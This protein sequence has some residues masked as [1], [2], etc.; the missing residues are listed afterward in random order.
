MG[1]GNDD[2]TESGEDRTTRHLRDLLKSES[3]IAASRQRNVKEQKAVLEELRKSEES[4]RKE[5]EQKLKVLQA[6]LAAGDERLNQRIRVQQQAIE[7]AEA[8]G[9]EADTIARKREELA[10]LMLLEARRREDKEEEIRLQKEL[11]ATFGTVEDAG[12]ELA[13]TL[14]GLDNRFLKVLHAMDESK[15]GID[16]LWK[17]FKKAAFE[18]GKWKMAMGAGFLK[19]SELATAGVMALS[20]QILKLAFAQDE[21]ISGFMKATGAA[22]GFAAEI[23]SINAD[24]H[25]SGIS[26]QDAG[27]AFGGLYNTFTDFTEI[28]PTM[29]GELSR[30]VA[31]LQELGQSAAISGKILDIAMRSL[32][33]HAKEAGNL[34][35]EVTSIAQATRQPFTKVAQDFATVAPKL[36]KYGNNMMAVFEGLEKQAKRTGIQMGKLISV[37]EQFDTFEGAGRAVGRLNAILGGP[38]LN[39]I[40]MLNATDEERI[41]IL[42]RLTEQSG[43]QFD[44]LNRYEQMNIAKAMGTDV[45]TARRMMGASTAEFEKQQ[46]AQERLA[47]MARESQTLIDQLK[48]AFQSALVGMRPIIEEFIVPFIHGIGE[49]NADMPKFMK[50]L[51]TLANW[52]LGATGFIGFLM[53]VSGIALILSGAGVAAGVPMAFAGAKLLG[54]GIGGAMAKS[55]IKGAAGESTSDMITKGRGRQQQFVSD[56][57]A[58]NVPDFPKFATGGTVMRARPGLSGAFLNRVLGRALTRTS[59]P[60]SALTIVGENGPELRE[61]PVGS[62]VTNAPTTAKLTAGMQEL[63]NVLFKV[64]GKM[65]AGEGQTIAVSLNVGEDQWTEQV[66]K[67]GKSSAFQRAVGGDMLS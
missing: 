38:Y 17:G 54:I 34:L 23:P 49:L 4:Y 52:A 58:V 45:D 61:S 2:D 41:D 14:F 19:I 29:R 60:M 35:L 46:L 24:L 9:A 67:A 44:E 47:A 50:K 36:T 12:A 56:V 22:Y 39:A 5:V 48:F 25:A 11:A 57:E 40:D 18:S 1:T 31:L 63:V 10:K 59:P 32:G 53:L 28:G 13:K 16:G 27:K 43:L 65:D 51:D 20:A 26:A 42:Q 62:R 37:T 7:T 6:D 55:A 3:Q 30:N 64:V 8:E 66:I 21:A 15:E 33:M